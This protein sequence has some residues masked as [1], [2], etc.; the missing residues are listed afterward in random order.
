MPVT[1]VFYSF[2]LVA[3]YLWVKKI[4][5]IVTSIITPSIVMKQHDFGFSSTVEYKYMDDQ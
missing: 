4:I 1:A 5:I 2:Y 3:L